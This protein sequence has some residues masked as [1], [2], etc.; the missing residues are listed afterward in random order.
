MFSTLGQPLVDGQ[1]LRGFERAGADGPV[2]ASQVARE[3]QDR[4]RQVLECLLNMS[5]RRDGVGE[6]P[7]L[8]LVRVCHGELL[9]VPREE[10]DEVELVVVQHAMLQEP[11]NVVD[12]VE[13]HHVFFDLS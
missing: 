11:R 10:G 12:L 8:Q 9:G 2:I 1:L 13:G 5:S 6:K 3:G 4:V 7:R